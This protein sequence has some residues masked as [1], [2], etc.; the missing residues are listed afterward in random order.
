MIHYFSFKCPDCN[1]IVDYVVDTGVPSLLHPIPA[2][3]T[4]YS[5]SATDYIRVVGVC[6]MHQNNSKMELAS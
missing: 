4:Y 3:T 6:Q 2:C 1:A 5:L